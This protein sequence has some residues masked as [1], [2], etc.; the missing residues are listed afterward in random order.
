[1]SSVGDDLVASPEHGV[2]QAVST[3]LR[4]LSEFVNTGVRSSG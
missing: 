1:M 2:G 3:V 4:E